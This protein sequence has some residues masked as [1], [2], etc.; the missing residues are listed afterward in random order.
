MEYSEEKT[1]LLE[2]ARD[3]LADEAEELLGDYRKT[4]WKTE[5]GMLYIAVL[6]DWAS[7]SSPTGKT[8]RP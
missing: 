7:P 5:T 4:F 1:A 3:I 8:K 6:R 2:K